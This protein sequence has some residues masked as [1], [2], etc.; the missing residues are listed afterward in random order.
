MGIVSDCFDFLHDLFNPLSP[1][2][3]NRLSAVEKQALGASA[4]K[5]QLASQLRAKETELSSAMN[6]KADYDPSEVREL[7]KQVC[8]TIVMLKM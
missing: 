7:E 1:L 3:V 5:S 8:N 6:K 2:P 4:E